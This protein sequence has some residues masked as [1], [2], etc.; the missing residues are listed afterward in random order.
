MSSRTKMRLALL[1]ILIL[2]VLAGVV[3][4]PQ[5]PDLR[6]GSYY[7]EIKVHLG[8][9]LQGG[10]SLLYKAD[11]TDIEDAERGSALEGVRDVIERRIDAFGVS[12]PNIQTVRSGEDW[13]ILVELPGVTDI[14]EAVNR[15]GE[16]PLLE[17]KKEGEP[18]EL[19]DEEKEEIRTANE[20]VKKKAEAVLAQALAGE[21]F[22]DLAREHSDDPGSAEEGGDLGEFE[23]GQMVPEFDEVVFEKATVGEVYPELVESSFGYHI[24]KLNARTIPEEAVATASAR[25][26]LFRTESETPPILG[27]NYEATGLT[28]EQ[29]DR[30]DVTLDPNT[31]LPTVSLSFN[32][33]GKELFGQITKENVGKTVAIYLDG[34][35]IS[36]PVVQQ[37]INTGEAVISGDFTLEEAKELAQRLNAGALP[38]PV[39][40]MSQQNVGPTLGQTS[41]ERSLFAGILGLILL[42]IFMIAYYRLPGLLAVLALTIYFMVVLAIFKLWPVT[43]TLAGIAGFILS[44][45]MAVDANVLIFERFKEELRSGKPVSQSIDEGF[46]RAWSSIRDANLSSLITCLILYW[47]GS[48]LIRGF[49]ITLAI[50]I[51]ISMFSAITITKNLL[52]VFRVKNLWWYGLKRTKK[53]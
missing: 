15:I 28:G 23:Q 52:G 8:L 43:L 32:K 16:T 39:E 53:Q 40:L 22:A 26:I 47:F 48:S 42:S 7:K 51:A 2:T 29:L 10:T 14:T 46:K 50:G 36:T 49:A 31:G 27:P 24:I 41:V 33:A 12:E 44:I 21:K 35:P 3:D 20:E 34:I 4:Y 19:T 1:G 5:G 11:V 37:E 17:F 38:V 13:R 6:I 9:D 18:P 25:H 30:A 45:G